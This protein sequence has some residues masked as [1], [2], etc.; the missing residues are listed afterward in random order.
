MN[1]FS[2]MYQQMIREMYQQMIREIDT[3][4]K[5]NSEQT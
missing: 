1:K 2:T 4:F 5:E 3:L